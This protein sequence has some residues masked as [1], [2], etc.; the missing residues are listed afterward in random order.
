M[1]ASQPHE[2][3][4]SCGDE[5]AAGSVLFSGRTKFAADG[6]PDAFLCGPCYTL[7]RSAKRPEKWAPKDVASFTRAASAM[8]LTW[9]GV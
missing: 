5:T 3:C 8:A 9:W 1:Q 7:V 6:F 4:A 2:P